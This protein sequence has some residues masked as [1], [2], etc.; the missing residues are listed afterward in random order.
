M[1][2]EVSNDESGPWM[3]DDQSEDY[4]VDGTAVYDYETYVDEDF[5][6]LE[7]TIRHCVLPSLES[8]AVPLARI[9]VACVALRLCTKSG[10]F[11][12][13]VVNFVST[14]VGLWL[15]YAF[16]QAKVAYL[17]LF[18]VLIYVGFQVQLNRGRTVSISHG[19]MAV[20]ITVTYLVVCE[21]FVVDEKSWHTIR[22]R[23]SPH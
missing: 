13:A 8:I 1:E 16:F 5:E 12:S 3:D 21:L 20:T 22:G 7:D 19:P 17:I 2:P 18:A 9:L 15:A 14:V 4:V 11:S 6:N 23:P 10:I